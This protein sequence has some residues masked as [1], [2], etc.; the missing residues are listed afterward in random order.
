MER[1]SPAGTGGMHNRP[2]GG[3]HRNAF[4][5]TARAMPFPT[6]TGLP[7][8]GDSKL[9]GIGQARNRPVPGHSPATL[10]KPDGCA[11]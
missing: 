3:G 9:A 10:T 7:E 5:G 8:L 1:P 6:K 11:I 4:N 2:N